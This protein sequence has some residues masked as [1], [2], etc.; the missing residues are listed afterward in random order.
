MAYYPQCTVL[1]L[2]AATHQ[3]EHDCE[4]NKTKKIVTVAGILN[5][6]LS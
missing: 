1:Y 6:F 4:K 2:H 5:V 3:N